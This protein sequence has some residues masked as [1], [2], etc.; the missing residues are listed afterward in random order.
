MAYLNKVMLIGNLGKDPEIR[1]TT[2]GK[3]KVSFSLATSRKYEGL[4]G[5]A[6]D[7]TDWHNVVGWGKTAELME[8]FHIAK[9][10]TL[11]VEGAVTYRTWEDQDGQKKFIT[12]IN[13]SSFQILKQSQPLEKEQAH[14][15]GAAPQ[16]DQSGSE[17]SMSYETAT[18]GDTDDLPF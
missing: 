12:E 13:L 11:Y 18:A 9:G 17:D 5:S 2:S 15:Y 10:N 4:D 6:H 1:V 16:A 3:K 7:Q 14:A 8:Q